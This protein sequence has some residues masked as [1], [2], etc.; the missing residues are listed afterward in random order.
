MIVRPFLSGARSRGRRGFLLLDEETGEALVIDPVDQL[1]AMSGFLATQRARLVGAVGTDLS[2]DGRRRLMACVG[3]LGIPIGSGDTRTFGRHSI[4]SFLSPDGL[5]ALIKAP[6]HLFT[7]TALLAGE[8]PGENSAVR[9]QRAGWLRDVLV[10][11]PPRLHIQPA[12]G[13]VSEI[14]LELTFNQEL[15]G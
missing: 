6:G 2:P 3:G 10:G 11:L 7:G 13:P 14:G 8:I 1:R 4:T 5:A 15:W 9:R 12:L